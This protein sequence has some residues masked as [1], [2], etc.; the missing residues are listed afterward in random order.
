EGPVLGQN[1]YGWM[2]DK[3]LKFGTHLYFLI[4]FPILYNTIFKGATQVGVD[5]RRFAHNCGG[6]LQWRVLLGLEVNVLRKLF[7]IV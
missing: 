4:S 1:Y 7:P 3:F 5:T 6:H 2:D